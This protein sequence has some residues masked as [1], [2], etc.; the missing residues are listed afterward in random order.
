MN[1]AAAA[2]CEGFSR[3]AEGYEQQAQLQRA[4]AW[5]LA[6][7]ISALP[8]QSGP[9]ADLGAGSGLVGQALRQLAPQLQLLQLDGS[10]ALLQRNPLANGSAL[11]LRWDLQQGLPASLQGSALLTSSF[12]LQWLSRPAEALKQWT[13]ALQPGGWLVLA[14]PVAGSFPQWHQAARCAQVPCTA[15]PL[16]SAHEL[17]EAAR[18]RLALRQQRELVFSRHYGPGGRAFLRQL[19]QLGA[20]HSNQPA[21]RPSQWRQLLHHWPADEQVSWRILMLIAQR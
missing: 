13:A 20:G 4:V 17:L 21:L 10:E 14:V 3:H 15:W 16:P 6:R 9:M 11:G 19:R 12:S 2:I 8:L 7:Q 1:S 5:R 18:S